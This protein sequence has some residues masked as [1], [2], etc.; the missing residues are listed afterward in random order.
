MVQTLGP[1]VISTVIAAS[2]SD[3]F[4]LLM[5]KTGAL[6]RSIGIPNKEET[7]LVKGEAVEIPTNQSLT[8]VC[9]ELSVK[10]V[11]ALTDIVVQATKT[12]KL[13]IKLLTLET[14]YDLVQK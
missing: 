10:N 14:I 11:S 4:S 3:V 8:G 13:T 1:D 9:T 6:G 12:G 2:F 7:E 5:S